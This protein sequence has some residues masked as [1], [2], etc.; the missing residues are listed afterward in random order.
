MHTDDPIEG[1]MDKAERAS[2]LCR[3]FSNPRRLLILCYLIKF[4]RLNVSDLGRFMP[5]ISQS[6]LSQHL[7]VLKS[8]N[9]VSVEKESQLSFYSVSHPSAQ[10]LLELL[11]SLYC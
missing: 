1:L 9:L 3:V 2:A 7:S 11:Q 5:E 8:E 10:K 6:A 4:K